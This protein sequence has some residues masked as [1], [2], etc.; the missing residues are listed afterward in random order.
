MH[1]RD[2]HNPFESAKINLD[3]FSTSFTFLA[4]LNEMATRMEEVDAVLSGS[5]NLP[6]E[7]FKQAVAE[8]AELELLFALTQAAIFQVAA[9]A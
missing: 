6:D 3:F 9:E 5:I 8:K 4:S 2:N 1:P 7:I